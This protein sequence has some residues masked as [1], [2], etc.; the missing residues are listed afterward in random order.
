MSEGFADYWAF[1]TSSAFRKASDSTVNDPCCLMEWD[2]TTCFRFIDVFK[3]KDV[4]KPD[5][6][7]N[8]TAHQNGL[9]WSATLVDIFNQLPDRQTA[10]RIILQSHFNVP[11]GPTFELAA[12]SII[13][14]DWQLFQGANRPALCMVFQRHNIYAANHCPVMTHTL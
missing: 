11:L 10:D 14:A 3:V 8:K 2:H 9:I 6:D 7:P 4:H 13:T 12:D 1:S 5:P